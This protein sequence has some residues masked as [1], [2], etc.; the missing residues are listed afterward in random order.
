MS[1]KNLFGKS[2]RNLE[3][4]VQDVESVKFVDTT[5][6]TYKKEGTVTEPLTV[7]LQSSVMDQLLHHRSLS[8]KNYST[9][10]T[11]SRMVR[12]KGMNLKTK[13]S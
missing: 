6:E 5:F 1:I 3:E 8:V 10:N 11:L 9:L 13:H 7:K 4:T 12:F 2:S